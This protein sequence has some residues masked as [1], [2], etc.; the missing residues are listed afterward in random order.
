[1]KAQRE[2]NQAGHPDTGASRKATV[3]GVDDG[4]A[5]IKL[6][7]YEPGTTTIR[8]AAVRSHAQSGADVISVSGEI[9]GAYETEGG[10]RF[11]VNPSIAGMDTRFPDFPTSPLNRVLVHHGLNEAGFSGMDVRIGTTLPPQQF[12]REGDGRTRLINGKRESLLKP[13]KSLSGQASPKVVDHEILPEAVAAVIDYTITDDGRIAQQFS[14]PIAVVDIGGR[15]TD[16]V[17]VLPD[18]QIDKSRMRTEHLGVLNVIDRVQTEVIDQFDLDPTDADAIDFDQA[19]R[20]R[21]IRLHGSESDI[22]QIVDGAIQE[23]GRRILH[24]VQTKI[25]GGASLEAILFV[26]GGAAVMRKVISQYPNALV[27]SN[28]QFANARGVLKA[29]TWDE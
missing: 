4:Y 16:V 28:P 12:F 29:L 20:N 22:S 6:A 5:F 23:V 17:V 8:T 11:T 19:V 25:A 15:T 18:N 13:V 24:V 7:W 26:G 27:H 21:K 10:E 2:D 3:V 9:M 1:M 14:A